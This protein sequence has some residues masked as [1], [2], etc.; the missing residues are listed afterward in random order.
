MT[1]ASRQTSIVK[2]YDLVQL[3]Y[4]GRTISYYFRTIIY[5]I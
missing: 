2:S 1:S 5:N 4:D 3:S